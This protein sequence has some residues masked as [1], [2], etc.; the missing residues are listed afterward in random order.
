MELNRH[1]YHSQEANR[2]YMS[3]S[4]Y[5]DFMVCE[6]MA[7]AKIAGLW[8]DQDTPA[9]L[10][11]SYVHAWNEGTLDE[12]KAEHPEIYY[13][14]GANQGELKADYQLADKM[15]ATLQADE[16]CMT[17]LQ[18][19]KEVILTAEF[20][21]APWK[22]RIDVYSPEQGFFADLKTTRSIT[23]KIWVPEYGRRESFVEAYYYP[24]QMTIYAEI[25]K[26]ATGSDTW[27]Q[28]YM[29]AVS[30]EDPPDKVVLG[31]IDAYRMD[32]ELT[33]IEL[34]MPRIIDLKDGVAKPERCGRCAYCRAT[35]KLDRVLHYSELGRLGK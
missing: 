8:Q 13:K 20:A 28:P 19:A 27:L 11:G 6:E 1:N 35:K 15:I 9:T 32:Y 34:N 4:Q 12:F 3:N 26:R 23:E 24:R 7:L 10:C 30:K 2:F 29:V 21:G 33:Q 25:E 22:I 16:L 31:F 14:A 17:Y 5:C 18:G